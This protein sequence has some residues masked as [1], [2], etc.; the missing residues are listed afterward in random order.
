MTPWPLIAVGV[1]NLLTAASFGAV[2]MHLVRRKVP[3]ADRLAVRA[4][5]TWWLSMGILVAIEGS[6]VLAASAGHI[7]LQASTIG[8]Y[9]NA[10]LLATGGWGLCFHVLYLRTGRRGWAL[11]LL[12]YYAAVALAYGASVVLYPLTGFET[13]GHQLVS[14]HEP[15]LEDSTLWTIVVAMVGLPLIIACVLYLVL[16]R[17]LVRRD[18]KRRAILA[19]SGILAWVAAG[20]VSQV[21]AGDGADFFTLTVMGVLAALLVLLAYF[22]PAVLR[23]ND[24]PGEFIE[25]V[26]PR[27]APTERLWDE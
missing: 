4:I 2:G 11:G 3:Q 15:V 5:A 1:V 19:S 22:P 20:A 27:M 14:Q 26:P 17:H 13:Q 9:A 6:E 24:A 7:D 25:V 10:L 21:V 23:R 16:S 8:R 18:Q 12:P